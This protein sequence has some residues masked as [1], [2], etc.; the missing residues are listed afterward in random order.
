[1]AQPLVLSH[2]Q[3][4]ALLAA[5]QAGQSTVCVT[6]D[7]N[8]T[9]VDATLDGNGVRFPTGDFLT[10]QQIGKIAES[11]N[12]CFLI[13][14]GEIRLIS[15]F[16]DQTNWARSL[17]PTSGAPSTLVA[18]FPMHRVKDTDPYVDTLKKVAALGPVVGNVLDTTTGLGY[19]AIELA[20]SATLVTTI[21]LDPAA[22]D[23]ARLNPWSQELFSNPRILSLTGDA[24]EVV[25]DFGDGSFSAILHD[26]P[27]F[28]LA[29][30]LYSE[31]FYLQ[32]HRILL[33]NGKMFHYVG[34]PESKLGKRMTA[35]VI[36][37]LQAAGFR[38]VVR[39]PD[40]FGVV[41]YK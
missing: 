37:R 18:G 29:G 40:A 23:I 4:E 26:P 34:D 14:S 28:S 36:E 3:A 6:P 30:E 16:S 38:R 27:T 11:D 32:L 8:R 19:T 21:E 9:Q 20:K 33:G 13:A 25:S 17:Y 15:I 31:K 1:M 24:F 5:R 2:F 41:A 7:L 35:G 39:K 22:L 10:W 12:Q